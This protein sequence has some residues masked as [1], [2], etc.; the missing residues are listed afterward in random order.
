MVRNITQLGPKEAEFLARLASSGH[1]IF[2]IEEARKYWRDPQVTRKRL[3]RLESKGWLERLERGTYMILPLEAG[4]ERLWSE[5]AVVVASWLIEPSAVAYW[6]ALHYWRMTE[7]S[8]R[9][10][11][12]QSTSR[13]YGGEKKVLGVVYRFITVVE[14]KFFG[15]VRRSIA[16]KGFFITDREKTLL[17]SL[18]RP[19]LAGG[20]GQIALA[21]R[22]E[23]QEL[24]WD[25]LDAHLDRLGV[26]AVVKR[27][28][29]LI[30]ALELDVPDRDQRLERWAGMLTTGISKLDPSSP[31]QVH[32]IHTRW[33]LGVNLDERVFGGRE[34]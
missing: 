12:V 19:D 13:K 28:G 14:R 7:Q 10:V 32:R 24:N 17:D 27:L 30:E 3:A 20:M 31:R 9:T 1:E 18:D 26:G 29:F 4:P 21:L 25:R 6:S 11:F 16:H 2:T 33:R 22:G 15:R 8:P 5:N 23:A 34:T